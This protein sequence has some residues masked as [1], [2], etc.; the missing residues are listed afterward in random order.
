MKDTNMAKKPLISEKGS[1]II[2]Y[3]W[4]ILLLISCFYSTTSNHKCFTISILALNITIPMTPLLFYIGLS[5]FMI[6]FVYI[7]SLKKGTINETTAFGFFI[8]GLSYAPMVITYY[9]LIFYEFDTYY[10]FLSG[11]IFPISMFIYEFY[12]RKQNVNENIKN[13]IQ[14]PFIIKLAGSYMIHIIVGFSS[15]L[16]LGYIYSIIVNIS[17]ESYIKENPSIILGGAALSGVSVAIA[18]QSESKKEDK[19]MLS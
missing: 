18:K 9:L 1:D 5:I 4:L 8:T 13:Q 2:S 6:I 19:K 16:F 11:W 15:I 10:T 7:T 14:L 17:F 12:L 3:I